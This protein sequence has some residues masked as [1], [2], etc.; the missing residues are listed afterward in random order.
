MELPT[1]VARF[2]GGLNVRGRFSIGSDR[3]RG[4]VSTLEYEFESDRLLGLGFAGVAPEVLDLVDIFRAAYLADRYAG[5]TWAGDE[6]PPEQRWTRR[7][8]LR[9]GLRVPAFWIHDMA[10]FKLD[11]LLWYLTGDEWI[12]DANQ[13]TSRSHPFDAQLPLPMDVERS[14]SSVQL[15]SGGIDSTYGLMLA[16]SDEGTRTLAV[17]TNTSARQSRLQSVILKSITRNQRRS[18]IAH[19]PVK[20]DVSR[21]LA[22]REPT[23]RTRLLLYLSSAILAAV[24]V[25]L[26]KVDVVEYGPGSVN[27][28]SSA[29]DSG[30]QLNR[31]MHPYTHR[32]ASEI[33]SLTLRRK[34]VV[35]NIA[36]DL[37]KRQMVEQL[38]DS[39]GV[40]LVDLTVSCDRFPYLPFNQA[41]GVCSSCLLRMISVNEKVVEKESVRYRNARKNNWI[42][43]RT[44]A[45]AIGHYLALAIQLRKVLNSPNW[46][47]KLEGV[48]PH[49]GEFQRIIGADELLSMLTHFEQEI[50][51]FERRTFGDD[52][53]LAYMLV[54][55]ASHRHAV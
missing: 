32:L 53:R 30:P 27:L 34:F 43:V 54:S 51:D 37:T 16:A 41:C 45:D 48:D 28:P 10:G 35:E 7:I 12:I 29:V 24:A 17:S 15:F 36:L 9:I 22:I 26:D 11:K 8:I 42:N 20:V 40:E 14:F 44:K 19:I 23:Q 21:V 39:K 52:D 2:R 49:I 25:G 1:Y 50:E 55:N 31:A 47:T 33:V 6:R 46:L 18:S 5:R 4:I 38:V 3:H 13:L